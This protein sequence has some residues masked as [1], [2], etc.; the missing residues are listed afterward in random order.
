MTER[1]P[2][3]IGWESWIDRQIRQAR[4]RGEFDE[5]AGTGEPIHD[6]GRPFDEMWWVKG[7][8]RQEGLSYLPPSLALRKEAHDALMAALRARSEAEVR[9][10]IE[11]VNAVIRK[12]NAHGI[13]GPPLLLVPFDVASV[14]GQWRDRREAR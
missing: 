4:E 8:L 13:N 12:A 2:A 14:V 10:I 3:G 11:D 5:L 7:K 9:Q 1:K 6:L